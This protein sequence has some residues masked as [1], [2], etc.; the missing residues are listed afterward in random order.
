M[1]RGRTITVNVSEDEK[2][3]YQHWAVDHAGGYMAKALQLFVQWIVATKPT[4][5]V[6]EAMLRID[7]KATPTIV[8]VLGETIGEIDPTDEMSMDDLARMGFPTFEGEEDTS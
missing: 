6:V 7:E 2:R 5:D 1:A 4:W 8:H 3:G